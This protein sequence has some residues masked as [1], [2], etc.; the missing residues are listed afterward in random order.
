MFGNIIFGTLMDKFGN[1]I[2]FSILGNA[3]FLLTFSFIG[4]VPFVPF[5]PTKRLI[6]VFRRPIEPGPILSYDL[7]D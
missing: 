1:P 7:F 6:Q 5:E 4:P 2:A 3:L